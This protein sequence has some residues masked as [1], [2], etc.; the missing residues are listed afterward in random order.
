M[1]TV[2]STSGPREWSRNCLEDEPDIPAPMDT[3]PSISGFRRLSWNRGDC[4]IDAPPQYESV[5]PVTELTSSSL[6]NRRRLSNWM[7]SSSGRVNSGC[8]RLLTWFRLVLRLSF[9]RRSA[10]DRVSSELPVSYTHTVPGRAAHHPHTGRWPSHRI[11]FARHALHVTLVGG[12]ARLDLSRG[13]A[14]A[15]VHCT[16]LARSSVGIGGTRCWTP[17]SRG[18]LPWTRRGKDLARTWR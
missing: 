18:S 11:F 13:S 9:S 3:T 14:W 12:H 5:P 16:P 4:S 8:N 6:L 15:H 2:P 7:L 1:G 17:R 10:A